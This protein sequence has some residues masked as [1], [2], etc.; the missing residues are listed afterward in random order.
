MRIAVI[1]GRYKNLNQLTRIANE[2]GHEL[3]MHEGHVHGQRVLEIQRHVSRA[4]VVVIVT[5]I[6]SHA[7][8]RIAK[9]WAKELGRPTL[10]VK[11]MGGARF[12]TLIEA[13]DRRARLG[14]PWP[15]ADSAE[16][17]TK[18]NSKQRVEELTPRH[19]ERSLRDEFGP[20]I[21]WVA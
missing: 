8:V 11:Q 10:I 7:A 13:I 5:G 21:A 14:W 6:N 12:A 2:L 19:A 15:G 9:D 18:P 16:R 4:D 17:H 3:E 1:G 20:Q